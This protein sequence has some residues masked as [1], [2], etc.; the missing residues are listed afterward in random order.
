MGMSRIGVDA[1]IRVNANGVTGIGRIS[2][3][4][5]IITWGIG[6]EGGPRSLGNQRLSVG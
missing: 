1:V 3:V 6:T 4:I 2:R 5:D